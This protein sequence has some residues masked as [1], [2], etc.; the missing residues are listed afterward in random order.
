MVLVYKQS[1][2]IYD[3]H[4]AKQVCKK[5]GKKKEKKSKVTDILQERYQLCE[6]EIVIRI[7]IY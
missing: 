3:E 6:L 4:R 1:Q 7:L 2:N 5:K